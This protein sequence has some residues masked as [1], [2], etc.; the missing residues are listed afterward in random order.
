MGEF[1][2]PGLLDGFRIYDVA[3]TAEQVTALHTGV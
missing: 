1:L 2:L 3:L